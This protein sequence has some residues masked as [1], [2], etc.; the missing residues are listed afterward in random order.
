MTTAIDTGRPSASA[1]SGQRQIGAS[2]LHV[3]PLA[4]SGNVFGWTAD[5]VSTNAI[6]DEYAAGGG[7]FVDTADSYAAGRS[8]IMIGNWMRDRRN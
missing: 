2:D 6:L 5:V 7:N 4:M 8:E 1:R 3:F